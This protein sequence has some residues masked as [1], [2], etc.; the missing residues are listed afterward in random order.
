MKQ[1]IINLAKKYIP[2]EIRVSLR[3]LNWR[4]YYI[5]QT[6]FLPSSA[7]GVYCPIAEKNFKAFLNIKNDQ[8]TPTNGARMRQRLVWLY[9]KNELDIFN[10]KARVLHVAPELSYMP[11][12]L[13]LKNLDYVPGDKMVEGYSN[14]K[15]VRNIDLTGLD[16]PDN[17]FDYVICNHVMEHIPDDKAAIAEMFRV[18]KKGGTAVITV[19]IDET[20]DKT[21]EDFSITAPK[22]REKHF[23]QWD[24]V[25]WYGR[26]IKDR[27]EKA[28]FK[29]DM[30]RY[31]ENFSKQDY[32]KYGLCDDIIV[33][34]KKP[35]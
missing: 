10:K 27:F 19:P 15:G 5:Q 24:H 12:L 21:Y 17:S 6:L 25:R 14:Q 7:P 34:A 1:Q 4:R 28:G 13:P 20:L 2:N 3:K 11:K 26:D 29:V 30:N 18:L 9:L 31:A 32:R 23:G 22:E 16:F 35:V 8:L 33:V